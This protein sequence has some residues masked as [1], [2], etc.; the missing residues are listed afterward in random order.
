MSKEKLI[1]DVFLAEFKGYDH[2]FISS[3][4]KIEAMDDGER[5]MYLEQVKQM[6][7]LPP[8]KQEWQEVMRGL[9]EYLALDS[10][11]EEERNGYRLAFVFLKKFHERIEKL[12]LRVENEQKKR[13]LLKISKALS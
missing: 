7:S 4:K 5:I 13:A 9:V 8:Y 10:L 2:A 6:T 1:M 12:S 3:D 11:T